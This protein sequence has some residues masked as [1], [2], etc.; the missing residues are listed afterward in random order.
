MQCLISTKI[1]TSLP[2][3]QEA[4]GKIIVRE[5]WATAEAH[6]S[7]VQLQGQ[8]VMLVTELVHRHQSSVGLSVV[9]KLSWSPHNISIQRGNSHMKIYLLSLGIRVNKSL[10]NKI[11]HCTHQDIYKE[12]KD[13]HI[14]KVLSHNN[15]SNV[16]AEVQNAT[17]AQE[18]NGGNP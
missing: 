16:M 6:E 4:H 9:Q 15:I 5:L 11:P 10:P 3:K 7:Q 18:N 8:C 12:K 17:V 13:M 2:Q 1:Q 14:H